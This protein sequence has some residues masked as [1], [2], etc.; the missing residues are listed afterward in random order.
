[1]AKTVQG[2]NATVG[3]WWLEG[4]PP[5]FWRW[6]SPWSIQ[7]SLCKVF[8]ELFNPIP[9]GLIFYYFLLGWG[10]WMTPPPSK[11]GPNWARKVL[12]TV[13]ETSQKIMGGDHICSKWQKKALYLAK[14]AIK[15]QMFLCFLLAEK[16]IILL[17]FYKKLM[18]DIFKC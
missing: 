17:I 18:V 9:V 4:R 10:H 15:N 11:I 13:L 2:C 3:P 1:M 5:C 16:L 8:D 7:W 6:T 14:T 12:H